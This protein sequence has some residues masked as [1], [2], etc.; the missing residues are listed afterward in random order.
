MQVFFS[1]AQSEVENVSFERARILTVHVLQGDSHDIADD[2]PHCQGFLFTL[3]FSSVYQIEQDSGQ[4]KRKHSAIHI[5][6]T[7]LC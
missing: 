6:R 5:D 1:Q 4:S 2:S 7:L 3:G